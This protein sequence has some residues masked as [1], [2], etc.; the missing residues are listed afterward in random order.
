M[1]QG[2]GGDA[3][4]AKEAMPLQTSFSIRAPLASLVLTRGFRLH[5]THMRGRLME[6]ER[7]S[8]V[9]NQCSESYIF[10][11]VYEWETLQH[12]ATHCNHRGSAAHCNT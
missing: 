4:E 5:Y 3:A 6:S 2:G 11:S 8:E 7:A 1:W 10:L 12:T 9:E